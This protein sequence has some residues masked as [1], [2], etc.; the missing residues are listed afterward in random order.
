MIYLYWAPPSQ[1]KSYL[2]TYTAIDLLKKGKVVFSNYPII[3]KIPL[4]IYKSVI[5]SIY[6]LFRKKPKYVSK[7]LSTFEWNVDFLYAN[8]NDC[9]VILD[10]AY[11]YFNS[12]KRSVEDDAHE[13]FATCGHNNVDFYIIAQ[14]YN[15]INLV[16]REIA[17]YYVWISKTSNPF[18]ILNRGGRDNELTPLF[19]TMEYYIS[20]DDFRMR[21]VKETAWQKKR[22]WFNKRIANAYNT[23]QFKKVPKPIKARKWNQSTDI[24]EKVI[25]IETKRED[26]MIEDFINS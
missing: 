24:I 22:I 14:H 1:G 25:E 7:E 21:R 26:E 9:A 10:E 4:P 3:Y 12:H 2:G 11:R 19:F 18:S 8:L 15:R 17:N 6:K 23:K 20:E 13:A 5:N 16:I